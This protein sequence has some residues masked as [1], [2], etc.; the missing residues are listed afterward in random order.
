[1]KDEVMGTKS[2]TTKQPGSGSSSPRRLT[3]VLLAFVFAL[4]FGPSTPASAAGGK[5]LWVA[6]Y[7][8]P[9]NGFDYASDVAASPDGSKVFAT[10]TTAGGAVSPGGGTV[11]VTGSSEDAGTGSAYATVAYDAATGASQW[12][13]RYHGPEDSDEASAIA[14]SPGGGKVFVTGSSRGTQSNLD[15]ATGAYQ[16]SNGN[17]VWASRYNGSANAFDAPASIAVSPGG[18]KVFVTGESEGLNG[19]FDWATVAYLA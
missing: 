8:S 10:G 2:Q 3:Q 11:F 4:A 1:M 18:S 13:R 9:G 15:Y 19:D 12:T 6:P 5:Q 16:T 17:R 14:V 7:A